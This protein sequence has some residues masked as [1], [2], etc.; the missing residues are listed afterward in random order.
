MLL[1][2][3]LK[4]YVLGHRRSAVSEVKASR[5]SFM[6]VLIAATAVLVSI[7]S[8]L[9]LRGVSCGQFKFAT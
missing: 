1:E 5:A 8:D 2:K 4:F 7:L 3:G 9:L 6:R